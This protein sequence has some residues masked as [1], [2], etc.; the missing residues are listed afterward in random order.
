MFYCVKLHYLREFHLSCILLSLE[1]GSVLR[2]AMV[3]EAIETAVKKGEASEQLT[4]NRDSV[5][6]AITIVQYLM[7]VKRHLTQ[8]VDCTTPATECDVR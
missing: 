5:A 6:A 4:V 8:A 1:Q 3:M 7:E 2:M